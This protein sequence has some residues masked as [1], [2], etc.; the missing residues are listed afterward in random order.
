MHHPSAP[1]APK[2]L[3]KEGLHIVRD[4]NSKNNKNEEVVN[5]QTK[6]DDVVVKNK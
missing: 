4:N 5:T 6:N 1:D 2:G 3:P